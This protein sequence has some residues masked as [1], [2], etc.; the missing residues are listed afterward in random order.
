MPHRSRTLLL[1]VYAVLAVLIFSL[2]ACSISKKNLVFEQ[3]TSFDTQVHEIVENT[4]SITG[5]RVFYFF[6][7]LANKEVVA[8]ALIALTLLLL[9]LGEKVLA[10]LFIIGTFTSVFASTYFKILFLRVRP[11]TEFVVITQGG[12]AFPSGHSILAMM[13]YG[14]IGYILVHSARHV[15]QKYL[16]TAITAAT[17]FLI[18]ISRVYLGVHWASDV[19]AGWLLGSVILIVL[20]FIFRHFH[21]KDDI[22]IHLAW[23]WR[24]AV[25]ITIVIALVCV[26]SYFYVTQAVEFRSIMDSVPIQ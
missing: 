7:N 2:L 11:T 25:S 5:A 18:G 24:L 14:F 6:T 22:T 23:G 9:V 8:I 10:V 16:I 17:I 1:C 3:I 20:M 26:I 13:F 15:W 12:Y 4:S 21:T 19:V